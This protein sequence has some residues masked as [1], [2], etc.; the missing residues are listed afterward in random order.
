M[1]FF[2]AFKLFILRLFQLI[3]RIIRTFIAYLLNFDNLCEFISI[4]LIFFSFSL[5]LEIALQ[6]IKDLNKNLTVHNFEIFSLYEAISSK[7]QYYHILISLNLFFV[8]IRTTLVFIYSKNTFRLIE[9]FLDGYTFL[10]FYFILLSIV[11]ID[12]IKFQFILVN[13]FTIY[14]G[15]NDIIWKLLQLLEFNK[16]IAYMHAQLNK[17]PKN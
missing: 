5:W 6:E 4:F 10:L 15:N 7:I 8:V 12:C 16:N 9:T 14:Y 2:F 11:S 3:Y 13:F 1:E 17:T